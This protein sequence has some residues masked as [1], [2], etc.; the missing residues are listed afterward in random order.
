[1]GRGRAAVLCGAKW[2]IWGGSVRIAIVDF[3]GYAFC[4]QLGS[5]LAARGH[6]VLYSCFSDFQ[7]TKGAMRVRS[8]APAT[9]STVSVSL[10]EPFYKYNYLKRRDQELRL[11]R[12]FAEDA[13]L[14]GA[15]V[16]VGANMPIEVH[17]SVVGALQHTA[18]VHWLQD[19]VSLAIRTILRRQ[20]GNIGRA[21]G[22]YY[23]WYEGRLLRKSDAIVAISKDFFDVLSGLKLDPRVCHV[24]PN[25]APLDELPVRPKDNPWARAHGLGGK[26]VLLYSGSMGLKH[27]PKPL[28][29]ASRRMRAYP[30]MAIVVVAEGAGADSLRQAKVQQGLDN[31]TLLSYQP[32]EML[33][34]VLGSADVLTALVENEAGKFCVPSKVLTYLCAERAV[35]AGIPAG[36]LAAEI[37]K[38][39]ALGVVVAPDDTEG[40]A[41]SAV[42]LL[43]SPEVCRGFAKRSRR[44][45]EEN[46]E[47]GRISAGFESILEDAVAHR[48]ASI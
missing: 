22:A 19:V 33:P 21:V 15:D 48:R 37:I 23:T 6:N 20:L 39:D 34:D 46:F 43:N 3:G 24:V 28:I 31:V 18:Y 35:L 9:F 45:A 8:D 41:A 5:A 44:Y 14:F 32:I 16:V 17:G 7:G 38:R 29:A 12:K 2:S 27:D 13:R 40:Y 4:A 25:W 42:E 36:N 26:R 47:I 30:D 11:G 1:V 10:G